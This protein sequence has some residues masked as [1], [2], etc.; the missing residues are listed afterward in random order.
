M[1]VFDHIDIY[2]FPTGRRTFAQRQIVERAIRLG[3]VA[4]GHH[5][6][7]AVAYDS[8]TLQL[9]INWK[10][11]HT[12]N[13]R[14]SPETVKLDQQLD[15]MVTGLD[16]YLDSQIR[17][18]G[19]DSEEGQAAIEI[20]HTALPDGP[21][22]ITQ[23]GF[24]Q[25][26]EAVKA[27]IVRLGQ[28]DLQAPIALLPELAKHIEQV[29]VHHAKYAKALDKDVKVGPSREE[30]RQRQAD[31]QELLAQSKVLILANYIAT[32]DS[33]A[34]REL[35]APIERQ[36]EAIRSARRRRRR[37]TDVDPTTGE[38]LIEQDDE[39]DEDEDQ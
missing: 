23:L 9:K 25:E 36:S 39:D 26:S 8:E 11:A 19:E 10:A 30:I 34:T 20:R 14:F 13:A 3:F 31:G 28:P 7:A 15:R 6:Q 24:D 17:L 35:L 27:L 2:V 16:G 29:H 38:D 5:A 4:L 12:S 21:A 32:K 1:K 37:P 22:A 18:Y 33:D